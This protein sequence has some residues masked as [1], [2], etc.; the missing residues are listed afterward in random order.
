M[1]EKKEEQKNQNTI[2]QLRS[3]YTYIQQLTAS[4]CF[5]AKKEWKRGVGKVKMGS[6]QGPPKHQNK[7]A[8]KPKAGVKINETVR[9]LSPSLSPFLFLKSSDWH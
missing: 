6:K 5:A 8:W 7:F 4:G 9:T 1:K 3:K 2:E